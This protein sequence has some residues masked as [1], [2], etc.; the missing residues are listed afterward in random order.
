ML[1]QTFD[2]IKKIQHL[3]EL[4][5]P[6]LFFGLAVWVVTPIMGNI[7]ILLSMQLDLLRNKNVPSKLLSLN[8][9]LLALIVLSVAIYV[10]SFEIF[11][12]TRIYLD[13]YK[14]LDTRG[15]FDNQFVRERYEFVL[16]LLLYP[17]HY[18]TDGSEYLCLFFFA[19]IANSLLAF[20]ISK[21][22]S[23]KYYPTLLLIV[24]STFFYY[25]QLF[26]MRQFL[27]ILLVMM[28]IAT[29]E[30]SWL[31]FIL[32]SLLAI[33]SHLSS[34]I[35]IVVG[36][37]AKIG[38]LVV[39]KFK[40]KLRKT[41]KIFLYGI[42][43]FILGFL[44]YIAWVIYNNPQEIYRYV[45]DLLSLLPEKKLSSTLQN[46]VTNYD[47]RDTDTFLFD[48]FR[49]VA[50]MA[51]A[52]MVFLQGFRQVTPKVLSFNI[53]YVISLLQ[54]AF[55]L[56]TGFNQRIAYL[57]LTFYG[58][59]FCI[60]LDDRFKIKTFG[61]ISLLTMFVAASNTYNFWRIQAFMIDADGWSFFDGQPLAMSC[62]DYLV[63]FFQ[64]LG[65]F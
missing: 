6:M 44:I 53:I 36:V 15:I 24:F 7:P 33:F 35:Y 22:L 55:I 43:G 31:M 18:L 57:F 4:R 61:I 58:L 23:P 3:A 45:N 63:Y 54:I 40:I 9:L 52:C 25:S 38:F 1:D 2:K 49:I 60:G 48:I 62:F 46:R 27:S 19:L 34:A 20:Y 50:T 10:S 21:K 17:I 8:N 32:W 11:A 39:K 47:G 65:R 13:V 64:H 12:D 26:Y 29:L 30:S 56:V 41:D 16:F 14:H 59:F 37:F 5:L 51:L 42:L 28:A